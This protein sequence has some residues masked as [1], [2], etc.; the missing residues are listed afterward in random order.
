MKAR[1]TNISKIIYLHDLVSP[2]LI[3]CY[4]GMIEQRE[5]ERGQDRRERNSEVAHVPKTCIRRHT[6]V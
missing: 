4:A 2:A 6:N 3:R 5:E 1:A